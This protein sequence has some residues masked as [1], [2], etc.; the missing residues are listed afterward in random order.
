MQYLSEL[1]FK[2]AEVLATLKQTP[3]EDE[4]TD[5]LVSYLQT[6][7]GKRQLLLTNI[8]ANLTDEDEPELRKQLAL[9]Q[10]FEAQAK[11]IQEHRQALLYAG[12]KSKRQLNVYKAIDENR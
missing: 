5:E 7:V 12:R 3:A 2:L 4:S 1:N 9:T 10:S 11:V 8:F 6:L